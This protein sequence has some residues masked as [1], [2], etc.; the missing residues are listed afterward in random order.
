MK[1]DDAFANAAHIPHSETYPEKWAQRA[2]AFRA[3]VNS[4]CDLSYGDT[5][6]QKLDLFHP[7]GTAKGTV[8][9]VHGGY[10]LRF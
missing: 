9:F 4:E 5:D 3:A 1:F 8:M 10:W 2:A 7:P 6:R